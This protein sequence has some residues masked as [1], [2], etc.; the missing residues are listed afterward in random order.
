MA[1]PFLIA[2]LTMSLMATSAAAGTIGDKEALAHVGQT[3]TVQGVVSE[4]RVSKKGNEFLNFG[5]PFP[6]QDFRAVIFA[7]Y[8]S[9]FGGVKEYGGK[10]VS[11]TGAIKLYQ[12]KPEIVLQSPSQ[13]QI[14]K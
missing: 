5:G 3:S 10:H 11:V 13:L 12:G 7:R 6:K 9:A 1:K 8:A 2:G 14:V 4:V